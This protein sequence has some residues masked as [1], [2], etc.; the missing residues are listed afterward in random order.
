M[1]PFIQCQIQVVPLKLVKSEDPP[2][3]GYCGSGWCPLAPI[4]AHSWD[5]EGT[6]YGELDISKLR[7]GPC[8]GR[9]ASSAV[10]AFSVLFIKLLFFPHVQDKHN[11]K[12]PFF[13]SKVR[14]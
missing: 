10:R 3:L 14:P 11:L 9:G 5:C 1:T 13:H 2:A 8:I 6:A 4:Y 7:C 12:N